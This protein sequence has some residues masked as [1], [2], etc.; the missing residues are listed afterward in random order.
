MVDDSG[1]LCRGRITGSN[2]RITGNNHSDITYDEFISHLIRQHTH[3]HNSQSHGSF[4]AFY[5]HPITHVHE[6]KW[7]IQS[8]DI[9]MMFV[10]CVL[11]FDVCKITCG[12]MC[13]VCVIACGGGGASI[14]RLACAAFART[15]SRSGMS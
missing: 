7:H 11:V 14:V 4:I 15:V 6:S 2:H 10:S 13:D 1:A 8:R 12:V 5:T 9:D 3:T